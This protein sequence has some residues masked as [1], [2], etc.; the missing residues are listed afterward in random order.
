MS[1]AHTASAASW[2]SIYEDLQ[3]LLSSFPFAQANG[4]DTFL[5]VDYGDGQ[6]KI[7][8]EAWEYFEPEVLSSIQGVLRRHVSEWEVIL[9]GGPKLGPQ[10]AVS[11][12]PDRLVKRWSTEQWYGDA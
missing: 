8:C 11:V 10:Q 5:V 9:V 1:D 6:H 4:R 2:Q 3:A 12:Y 7:E